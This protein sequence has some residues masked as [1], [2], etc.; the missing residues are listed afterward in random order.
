MQKK[1]CGLVLCSL[2]SC[3]A[4]AIET[5]LFAEEVAC[6]RDEDCIVV[7][8]TSCGY[9]NGSKIAVNVDSEEVVMARQPQIALPGVAEVDASCS[10]TGAACVDG[11]CAVTYWPTWEDPR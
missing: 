1:L 6:E 10:A 11:E 5:E 8:P 9:A 4:P 7:E 2:S 3:A